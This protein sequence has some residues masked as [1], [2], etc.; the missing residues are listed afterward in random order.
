M[1]NF[2]FVLIIDYRRI[3]PRWIIINVRNSKTA[4]ISVMCIFQLFNAMIFIIFENKIE[5]KLL[6]KIDK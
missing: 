4:Q 5:N 3:L 2:C 6:N 1:V